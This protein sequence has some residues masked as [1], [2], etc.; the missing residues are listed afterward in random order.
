MPWGGAGH[1]LVPLPEQAASSLGLR[2]RGEMGA[3]H[4]E[5]RHLGSVPQLQESLGTPGRGRDREK[6]NPGSRNERR[7]DGPSKGT[8]APW[9]WRSEGLWPFPS[10]TEPGPCL[11]PG[12][13][14]HISDG[15]RAG[16]GMWP[17]WPW[18]GVTG[19]PRRTAPGG[20]W[21]S[22]SPLWG[23]QLGVSWDRSASDVAQGHM[24][25]RA[26]A[27]SKVSF[28]CNEPPGHAPVRKRQGGLL[29]P[30]HLSS[31]SSWGSSGFKTL[32]TPTLGGSVSV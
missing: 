5:P 7:A 1:A 28:L 21:S 26:W 23:A 30:T 29:Q 22:P 2:V 27:V 18:S 14:P 15:W 10:A 6:W 12:C 25:L 8:Q 16:A 9:G 19:F 17:P 3:L 24:G 32:G 13:S 31:N 20:P 4:P 11:G